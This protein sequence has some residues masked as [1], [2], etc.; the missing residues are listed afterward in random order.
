ML[1][2][3]FLIPSPIALLN[4]QHR[5]RV[6]LWHLPNRYAGYFFHRL[7]VNHRHGVRPG[8]GVLLSGVSVTQSGAAPTSA[9]PNSFKSGS[10]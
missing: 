7:E 3:G 10:E 2:V 5:R 1:P 4:L 6:P 8:V 9:P